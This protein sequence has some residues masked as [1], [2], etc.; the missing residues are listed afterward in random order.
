MSHKLTLEV[1]CQFYGEN[2]TEQ[3][4]VMENLRNVLASVVSLMDVSVGTFVTS[5]VVSTDD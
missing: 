1:S 2:D 3:L 4:E 5:K